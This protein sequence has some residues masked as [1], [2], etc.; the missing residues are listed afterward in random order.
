MRTTV[1][2]SA[3][4]L[5]WALLLT[6]PEAA[7]GQGS[8]VFT[9]VAVVD[10]TGAAA[11][12]DMSVVVSGGRIVGLG[13]AGRVRLPKDARV[14]DASGKF[15]IPGLWDMHVHEW[16][17][18]VFFPLFIANGVTGVR[19]MFSPLPPIKQ[20][21]AEIAAR[22][23]T[24][25]RIVAAGII[26]DGPNPGCAPCTIAVGN[27]EEGRKAVSKVREMGADFVKVYSMLPRD[28]YFAIADEAKRQRVVFAGHVPE[29]VSAAEAS[30]AGQK[31]IE[32]LSGVIVAC[33]AKEEG[34]RKESEARLRAE[35]IRR[36]TATLEQAAALDSF[37][38]KK[39]AALFSRFVRNGTWMCP[40]LS[41]LRAVALS[42][43]ADFRD[44]P[45]MKYIPDFLKNQFWEDAYG[46]KGHTAEDNA[47]AKR[48][49]QK[50]LEMVGM[51][52]R[53]GVRFIAGTDTANPHIFP[54][55]SLHEELALLVRAGFTPMQALQSATRDAAEYLG[56]LDS[57]GTIE[58]GKAADMV[59]LDADPL[60]DIGNTKKI[61][62]VVLGGKLISKQ[63]LD[64]MLADVEAAVG[65]R[66]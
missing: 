46:W 27:A 19:D 32:H 54:G 2:L 45:R 9:H 17:K 4:L 36:D 31:S 12:P 59:L 14:V 29:F 15:L 11:K 38:E 1:R 25:P 33:S 3:I 39:A 21:R 49:F 6:L 22:T 48:V 34:L 13:R 26:V 40:T 58:K 55:F 43:D 20:W 37:D 64:K 47:R 16:N 65:K 28:A 62:A 8:L 23:T 44:D 57:V 24:G 56:R 5:C 42:G 7:S 41:V 53:A 30:D 63:D 66:P 35:G 52:R 61:N 60:A 18:E 51:M 10:A 50:Q